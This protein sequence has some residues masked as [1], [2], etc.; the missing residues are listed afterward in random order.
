[1][2]ERLPAGLPDCCTALPPAG[3]TAVVMRPPRARFAVTACRP[4]SHHE[5]NTTWHD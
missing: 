1:M 5:V 3:G 4:M 2:T